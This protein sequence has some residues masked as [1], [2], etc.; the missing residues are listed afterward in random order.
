MTFA[1]S[2]QFVFRLKNDD[3]DLE[4]DLGD[5]ISVWST[6]DFYGSD[7]ITTKNVKTPEFELKGAVS[8]AATASILA[9]VLLF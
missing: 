7:D 2:D 5:I 8:L 9:T 1:D 3:S 6:R 4:P